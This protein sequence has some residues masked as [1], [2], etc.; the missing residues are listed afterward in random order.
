M[1]TLKVGDKVMWSDSWGT[2]TPKVAII[3]HLEQTKNV[4]E[5]DGEVVESIEWGTPFVCDL[6]NGRWAYSTQITPYVNEYA[7]NILDMFKKAS[8]CVFT[9]EREN[10]SVQSV[11]V[12]EHEQGTFEVLFNGSMLIDEE[13]IS[14]VFIKNNNTLVLNLS[15][16]YGV[17]G[18]YILELYTK[19]K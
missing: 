4:N 14:E 19:I 13:N 12:V 11:D 9:D 3:K 18:V 5:K 6:E 16:D 10:E 7:D 8:L 15:L 2:A 1:N 17:A